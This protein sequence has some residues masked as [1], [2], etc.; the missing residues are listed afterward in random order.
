MVTNTQPTIPA[1]VSTTTAVKPPTSG[2][3]NTVTKMA[4]P[5]AIPADYAALG[6]TS[7][8]NPLPAEQLRLWLIALPGAGKSTFL[9]S[10]PDTLILDF[11]AGCNAVPGARAHRVYVENKEHFDSI[12][13]KLI[14][15]GNNNN[16]R[17]KRVAFDTMDQYVSL[18]A[19]P[20]A[21]EKKVETIGEFG[22]KGAGWFLLSNRCWTAFEQLKSVGYAYAAAGHIKEETITMPGSKN[23]ITRQRPC[24]F[25]T[26]AETVTRNSDL[27]ATLTKSTTEK[28]IM[29]ETTVQ[30]NKINVPTGE[31]LQEVHHRLNIAALDSPTSK[32]RGVPTMSTR[33]DLSMYNGWDSFVEQYDEAVKRQRA[34][35]K[36][37]GIV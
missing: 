10:I 5:S 31:V 32:A 1:P 3:L 24:I 2:G 21:I 7:G 17:Y 34:E 25:K 16:R 20:L 26:L 9:S 14:E 15:D 8:Y 27:F 11:E 6:V 19:A 18:T 37:K 4:T 35:L 13:T 36:A 23:E 12:I 28:Q 33:I 29:K 22:S 30:G